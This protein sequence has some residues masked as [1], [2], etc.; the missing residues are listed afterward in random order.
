MLF[1]SLSI[2]PLL[3]LGTYTV[4]SST[5]ELEKQAINSFVHDIS[6]RVEKVKFFLRGTESD[7]LFLS[8]A[9]PIQGIIRARQGNGYD[10]VTNFT[11]DQWINRLQVI[12]KSF[13]RK[14]PRYLQI[15]YIDETGQEIVRIDSNGTTPR[16]IPK[17]QLKN[18]SRQGSFVETVN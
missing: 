2:I 4:I 16:L 5:K 12:F 10:E 8:E 1:L 3:L 17:E 13:T 9:P 14:N 6:L 15:R 7:L 18:I 11:Y